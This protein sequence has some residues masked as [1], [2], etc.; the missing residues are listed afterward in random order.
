MSYCF[1]SQFRPLGSLGREELVR[2]LSCEGEALTQEEAEEMILSLP[3]KD[4]DIVDLDQ[5]ASQL[6]P[7]P[8]FH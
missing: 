6:T 3:M 8:K 7:P 1:Y 4:T 5:Y 2:L